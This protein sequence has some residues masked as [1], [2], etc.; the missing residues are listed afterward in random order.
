[1]LLF[2]SFYSVFRRSARRALLYVAWKKLNRVLGAKERARGRQRKFFSYASAQLVIFLSKK[3]KKK[4]VPPPRGL[5]LRMQS[6]L[7]GRALS[8]VPSRSTQPVRWNPKRSLG[9]LCRNKAMML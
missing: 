3:K 4:L 7:S 9:S 5:V 8:A 2:L 1:M 6:A